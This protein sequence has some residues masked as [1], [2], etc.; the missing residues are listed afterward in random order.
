MAALLN[1][2]WATS[3]LI[4]PLAAGGIAQTAGDRA[5]FVVLIALSLAAAAWFASI[6]R[7]PPHPAADPA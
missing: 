1:M 5:A 2:V 6:D 7:V 4:G 3:A